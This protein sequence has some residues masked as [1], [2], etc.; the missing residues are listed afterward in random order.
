VSLDLYLVRHAPHELQG[1]VMVGRRPGVRLGPEAPKRLDWL[2]QCL[3]GAR[4]DSVV[5]SPLQRAQETAWAIAEPR[6]LAVETDPDLDEIDCGAWTGR[7]MS[8][9]DGDPD[10]TIWNRVRAQAKAPGGESLAEVQARMA[11]ATERLI[12]ER[13][14]TGVVVVSHGDPI[15]LALCWRLGW[16]VDRI[17]HF[18]IEPGSISALSISDRGAY[19]RFLN[20]RPD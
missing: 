2:Q 8:E 10:W 17:D 4:I 1:R 9:L 11:R 18:D 19:L 13:D 15:K 12:R 7:A 16:G 20:E 5:A 3:A 6:G 14:G